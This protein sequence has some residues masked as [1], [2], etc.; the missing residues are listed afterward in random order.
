M[1]ALKCPVNDSQTTSWRTAIKNSLVNSVA[2]HLQGD[3]PENPVPAHERTLWICV[4]KD[5]THTNRDM[6]ENIN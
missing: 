6:P 5:W 2:M 3:I 1:Q 4:G